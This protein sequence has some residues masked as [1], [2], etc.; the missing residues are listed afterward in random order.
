MAMIEKLVNIDKISYDP[1]RK[2]YLVVLKTSDQNK[3]LEILVGTK[4]A[5]E[6]ALAKEGVNFPRPSTHELLLDIIDNFEVKLKKIVI[7]DYK[8]ST[9]FAKIVLFNHNYGEVVVDSRPSD[10]IILSL[11]ANAPLYINNDII[12]VPIAEPETEKDSNYLDLDNTSNIYSNTVLM[13]KKL[14]QNLE[15]AIEFEEYEKAAKLRDKIN[16]LKKD[17]KA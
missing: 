2:G 17:V 12:G 4:A 3:S 9:F 7:T 6:I 10:A 15:K 13:L 11:R 8:S 1:G 14:N 16:N 5:K